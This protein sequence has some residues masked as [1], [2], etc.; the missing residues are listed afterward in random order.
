M[1]NLHPT[2]QQNDLGRFNFMNHVPKLLCN[3]LMVYFCWLS[4]HSSLPSLW[5]QG[6]VIGGKVGHRDWAWAKCIDGDTHMH[7]SDITWASQITVNSTVCSTACVGYVRAPHH[8]P[9]VR[10]IHWRLVDSPHK[11]RVIQEA[12]PRYC[13][14]MGIES[15]SLVHNILTFKVTDRNITENIFKWIFLKFSI[16]HNITKIPKDEIHKKSTLAQGMAYLADSNRL[17]QSIM[18]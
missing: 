1:Q 7:Y 3:F 2:M 11:G 9:L 17:I 16:L 8:W 4:M 18:I 5:T 10:G 12:F 6:E 14:I 13:V 15:T